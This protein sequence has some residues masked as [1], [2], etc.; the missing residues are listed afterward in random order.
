MKILY[1]ITKSNF[2]GA[3][4]YVFD[5]ARGAR[6]AGHDVVVCA[7]GSGLL[8]ERLH[9]EGI[10]TRTIRSLQRDIA[11][12][13]E[14]R[15]VLAFFHILRTERPDV[16]HLN[17]SK[18]GA[19]GSMVARFVNLFRF[20][21]R[22]S[23]MKIVY[24]G[25]GWAFNE[26]RND[27]EKVLIHVIHWVTILCSHVVIAV[28]EQ[29]ARDVARLPFVGGKLRVVHNGIGE[30]QAFSRE[31]ARRKLGIPT[32]K[33]DTY[34]IGT[35]AELHK[36]KGHYYAFM[37]I[38]QLLRKTDSKIYY[39]VCGSGGEEDELR[40]LAKDLDIEHVVYFAGYHQHGARFLHAFDLLLLPS[41]TEAF[42][43]VVLEAATVA[44]PVVATAVGGIPE[45]IE[46]MKSGILIQS[47]NA[48]EIAR[49]VQY[50][51]E[52]REDVRH[53]GQELYVRVKQSYT[54]EKMI[55]KTLEQYRKEE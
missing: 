27:L 18:A 46:D 53:F 12:L 52:H 33:D 38:A 54:L 40:Q 24:T 30:M 31:E 16:V 3:Q 25:H 42:P 43:Y 49:A 50:C 9:A 32:L 37:G 28:S 4:R 34:V 48:G 23:P 11:L 6:D 14:W 20:V 55:A 13:A 19:M 45:V 47:R 41:I 35:L 29:T 39:V 2:G 36:N 7:G 15:S 21:F 17:S 10:R 22:T 51:E 26:H 44:L 8:I 1:F 5:I